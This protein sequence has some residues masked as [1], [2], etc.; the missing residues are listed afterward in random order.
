[1]CEGKFFIAFFPK[2]RAIEYI[3][4]PYW[5]FCF[6]LLSSL[7]SLLVFFFFLSSFGAFCSA[8]SSIEC[9]IFL[10]NN[11]VL[12]AHLFFQ[13]NFVFS[14]SSEKKNPMGHLSEFY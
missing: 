13:K 9:L 8:V 12:L 11:K 7:F 14:S 5:L 2:E 6:V 1:M 3:Y 4:Q 10:F